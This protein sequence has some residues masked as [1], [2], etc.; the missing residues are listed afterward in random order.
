MV[1]TNEYWNPGAASAASGERPSGADTR[2][3]VHAGLKH[4]T[5]LMVLLRRRPTGGPVRT[6]P[7]SRIGLQ[8]ASL[9]PPDG[10]ASAASDGGPVDVWRC[11]GCTMA[12]TIK[13]RVLMVLLRRRPTHRT[14]MV[15]RTLLVMQSAA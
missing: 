15:P 3:Q 14:L 6:A 10:A 8:P 4:R 12:G 1:S 13:G 2:F 11:G 7:N 5:H 9:G